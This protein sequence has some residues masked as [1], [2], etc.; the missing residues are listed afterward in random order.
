MSV[1]RHIVFF[2]IEAQVDAIA[3]TWG[4]KGIMK[5][6]TENKRNTNRYHFND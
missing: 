1:C 6:Q 4:F 2:P 3:R 5:K